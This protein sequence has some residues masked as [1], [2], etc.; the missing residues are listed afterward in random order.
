MIFFAVIDEGCNSIFLDQVGLV[1]CFTNSIRMR[2]IFESS[3][4]IITNI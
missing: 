1:N 2:S 3:S 4:S